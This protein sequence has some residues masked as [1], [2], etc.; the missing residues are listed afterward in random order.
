MSKNNSPVEIAIV[1]I[2]FDRELSYDTSGLRFVNDGRQVVILA[3]EWLKKFTKEFEM[4]I[5]GL[6][7]VLLRTTFAGLLIGMASTAVQAQDG[8]RP[9]YNSANNVFNNYFTQGS[10][11]QATAAAYIS[12][13]GVPGWVGHTYITY[14]PLYPHEFMHH[15]QHR[16]HSYYDGGAGLNRT[17]VHYYSPPARTAATRVFKKLQL[18][19]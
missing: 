7:K 8:Y 16:Y 14:E 1:T 17:S 11:N 12:P 5:D 3:T 15:H 10:A 18:P 13:V 2:A 4:R 9:M 19:H 6:I